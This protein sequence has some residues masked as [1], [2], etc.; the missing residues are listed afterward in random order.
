MHLGFYCLHFWELNSTHHRERESFVRFCMKSQDL[1]LLQK[2]TKK[3]GIP[4]CW[5]QQRSSE[6]LKGLS[7]PLPSPPRAAMGHS[8]RHIPGSEQ[9]DTSGSGLDKHLLYEGLLGDKTKGLSSGSWRRA[10]FSQQ[11]CFCPF[12]PSH[13]TTTIASPPTTCI[14]PRAALTGEILP[15]HGSPHSV[16]L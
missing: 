5:C 7:L 6:E 11:R 10:W 15:L 13:R 4:P 3:K 12:P 2:Q 9:H 14:L 8:A 16:S 1:D